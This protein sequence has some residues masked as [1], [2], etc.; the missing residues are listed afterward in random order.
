MEIALR[1]VVQHS[2]SHCANRSHPR[3]PLPAGVWQKLSRLAQV[4]GISRVAKHAARITSFGPI[5]HPRAGGPR[6]SWLACSGI[7]SAQVGKLHPSGTS[8]GRLLGLSASWASRSQAPRPQRHGAAWSHRSPLS[9]SP[10]VEIAFRSNLTPYS[11]AGQPPAF[12]SLPPNLR[13]A[14]PTLWKSLSSDWAG[15][16]VPS[17]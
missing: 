16:S 12:A 15:Q 2:E 17:G 5:R 13:T 4:Y 1:P 11:S 8:K 9:C 10:V 3:A 7:G 14:W 6:F